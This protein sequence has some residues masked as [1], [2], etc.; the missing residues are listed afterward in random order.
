LFEPRKFIEDLFPTRH[1]K[2]VRE[3]IVEAGLKP[4][5]M[6]TLMIT[7]ECNQHCGHCLL[8]CTSSQAVQPVPKQV[9]MKLIEEFSGLGGRR[10]VLTGGEAL[11]HPHWFEILHT[12]LTHFSYRE[13]C[14]QTNA[15]LLKADIVSALASLPENK[16]SLQISLD[17]ASAEIHDS[18]R[19]KGSFDATMKGLRLLSRYGLCRQTRIAFTEMR[20]NFHE[21]PR[22]LELVDS[23]G[24]ASLVS[25]TLVKGGR[26]AQ[27]DRMALPLPEQY[28]ELIALYHRDPRFRRLYG[29]YA[30]IAAIEW[31][32]GQH[33]SA[34]DN[35]TCIQNLFISAD[36]S[37]YPCTMMHNPHYA[38]QNAHNQPL[39]TLIAHALCLW[40]ELPALSRLRQ[41]EIERCTGCPGQAHCT[42][43][44]LGRAFAAYGELMREEDRC[45]LRR[46]VYGICMKKQETGRYEK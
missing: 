7:A 1:A 17:G 36:G 5:E 11:T 18:V 38:I 14:L 29:Q 42:G 35:C 31:Y 13:V 33:I 44:C 20:H 3:Q 10:L 8:G 45:S 39:E 46:A 19:G 43:G 15:T 2:E 23:L 6:L 32:K 9:L 24:I 27:T 4:P 30:N 26:A 37:I 12:T 41:T 34:S 22:L 25:N 21:L 40:G 16:L 28:R